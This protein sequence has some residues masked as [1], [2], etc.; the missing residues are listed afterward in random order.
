MGIGGSTMGL[1]WLL[2]DAS[3][4]EL[5]DGWRRIVYRPRHGKPPLAVRSAHTA[6][7]AF[8]WARERYLGASEEEAHTGVLLADPP[9]S[10]RID[11]P[12]SS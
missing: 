7:A 11:M 4:Q 1:G 5:S 3:Y 9:H 10:R 6:A 12:N 2:P 8:G